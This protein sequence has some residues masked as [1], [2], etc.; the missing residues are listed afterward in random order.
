MP[1][2]YCAGARTPVTSLHA[3]SECRGP[4]DGYPSI[5]YRRRPRRCALLPDAA[6]RG[7]P[8][9]PPSSRQG[10]SEVTMVSGF[11]SPVDMA[12]APDGRIFVAEKAGYVR[13]VHANGTL[14]STPLL[15]LRNK[16]NHYSDR[17]MLG[18][19]VDKDFATNGYVYLLYVFELNPLHPDE[20]SPMTARLTRIKVNPDNTV[21][22]SGHAGEPGDG[23]RRQGLQPAV[24]G[25]GQ[26]RRLHPGRLQVAHDRNGQ[27]GPGGRDALAR[28]RRHALQRDR[29]VALA[30][31]RRG[32]H[33][34][35]DHA[36]RPQRPRAAQPPVLP[37]RREPRPH[38]HEDLRQGLPQPVPLQ[39]APGQGPGGG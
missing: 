33:G 3:D 12:Y 35:Q 17:G 15:D 23:H 22:P 14:R 13:V 2:V 11:N 20:D 31:L 6:G 9:R 32:Q 24:P 36:R 5:P 21:A 37:L 8:R 16:V 28:R 19:E 1:R 25:L 18:I 10:F 4:S 27:V 38:L 26:Q 30:S 34:R 7:A 29:R 39:P